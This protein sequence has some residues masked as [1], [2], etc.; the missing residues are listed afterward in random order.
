L[1]YI[2]IG[3]VFESP[4]AGIFLCR[5]EGRSFDKHEAGEG[6]KKTNNLV[7]GPTIRKAEQVTMEYI[8]EATGKLENFFVSP[9]IKGHL[10]AADPQSFQTSLCLPFP[11][12]S[13]FS[14]VCSPST[15]KGLHS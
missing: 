12:Q 7:V 1:Y 11:H 9:H 10:E 6:I 2:R 15:G 14:F 4:F 13:L 5:K 8:R 3:F